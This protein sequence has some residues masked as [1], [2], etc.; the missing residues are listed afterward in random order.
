M[1][2]YPNLRIY[3]KRRRSKAKIIYK[4]SEEEVYS[5]FILFNE[6]AHH[7]LQKNS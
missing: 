2:V 1:T 4:R 3:C 7:H 6:H 5:L